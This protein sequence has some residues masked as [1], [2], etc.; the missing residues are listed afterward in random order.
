MVY[1]R[2]IWKVLS[3]WNKIMVWSYPLHPYLCMKVWNWANF[4]LNWRRHMHFVSSAYAH[5]TITW[6][7][8]LSHSFM[9]IITFRC[10]WCSLSLITIYHAIRSG[11]GWWASK[12]TGD[13]LKLQTLKSSPEAQARFCLKWISTHK[14][15]VNN[16]WVDG[17]TDGWMRHEPAIFPMVK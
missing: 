15:W 13:D 14:H 9:T 8:P 10:K 5:W 12:T 16:C 1:N 17:W 6:L 2:E 3:L 7:V 11:K 4:S